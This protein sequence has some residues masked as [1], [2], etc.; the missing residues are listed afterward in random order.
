MSG[1][2]KWSSIKHKKARTDD[3]RG[4]VFTKLIY[5]KHTDIIFFI[6][7]SFFKRFGKD[8]SFRKYLK[9]R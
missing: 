7:S 8:D 3:K 2:S 1:H 9:Y 4:K 5:T 6:S